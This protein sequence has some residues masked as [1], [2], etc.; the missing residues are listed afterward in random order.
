[1][2]NRALVLLISIFLLSLNLAK[3]Q[4]KV[5]KS[6]DVPTIKW[7]TFEEAIKKNKKK[8]KKIFID[9]YTDWCGWC[10]KMDKET[11]TDAAIVD[12][13]NKNYYAVKFN[14][15]QK[16]PVTFNGV[17]YINTN[18]DKQ[19]SP[20]QLA[21]TLLQKEMGYPSFV[22]LD[23]KS[24]WLHK[25]RGYKNAEALLPILKYYGSD[26]YKVMSWSDFTNSKNL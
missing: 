6:E 12:Y 26:Q 25:I 19:K 23:G 10:K 17:E 21:V 5:Q 1:M 24:E 15:E 9:M 20:H 16:E 14:A 3:A 2:K 4:D 11:F 13:I 8:P 22:I 7:M 18:P